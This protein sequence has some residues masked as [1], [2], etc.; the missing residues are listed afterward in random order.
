MSFILFQLLP[1]LLLGF[2][3]YP[4]RFQCYIRL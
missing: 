3:L 4:N 2:G 1:W